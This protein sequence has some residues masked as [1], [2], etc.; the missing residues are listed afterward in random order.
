E[1]KISN[2]EKTLET[3]PSKDFE[4]R[5]LRKCYKCHK[6]GHFARDCSSGGD[7]RGEGYRG[8]SISSSRVSCYNC[9]VSGHFARECRESDK[10]CYICRKAGHISR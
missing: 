5:M 8:D 3:H 4:K 7:G 9:G 10:T 1:L 2:L 6:P